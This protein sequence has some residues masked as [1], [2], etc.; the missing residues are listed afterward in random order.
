MLDSIGAE[1]VFNLVKRLNDEGLTIIMS[2]HR[3]ERVIGMVD[4]I[5]GL[6]DGTIYIDDEPHK[7][8]AKDL[9]KLGVEEPQVTTLYRMINKNADYYPISVDEFLEMS[10]ADKLNVVERRRED[11]GEVA[12][13]VSNVRF[14]YRVVRRRF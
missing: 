13:A 10:V 5:I 7:A 4:R 6:K 2:E 9:T 12:V 3:V 14:T 8:V 1:Q 11:D